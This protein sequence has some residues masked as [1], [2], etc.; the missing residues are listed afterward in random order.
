[1]IK[2]IVNYEQFNL[3]NQRD[4]YFV[5]PQKDNARYTFITEFEL[6]EDEL[7]VL[8][9]ELIEVIYKKEVDGIIIN[10]PLQFRRIAYY[11]AKHDTSFIYITLHFDIEAM[12]YHYNS[13]VIWI[14]YFMG[15]F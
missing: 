4:I 7:S 6:K 12:R 10:K 2:K 14:F 3:F 13:S 15:D 1:M 5:I 11:S 8:K 9:D